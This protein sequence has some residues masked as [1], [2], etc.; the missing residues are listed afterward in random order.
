MTCMSVKQIKEEILM[1][2]SKPTYVD[3]RLGFEINLYIKNR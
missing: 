3:H 2:W 1:Q